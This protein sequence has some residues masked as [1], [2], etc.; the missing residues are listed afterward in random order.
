[1]NRGQV[2]LKSICSMCLLLPLLAGCKPYSSAGLFI[3]NRSGRDIIVKANLNSDEYVEYYVCSADNVELSSTGR[4][5][6]HI[7]EAFISDFVSNPDASVQI[8]VEKGDELIL[9]KEWK[10]S[11]KDE[12]GRQFF[13]ELFLYRITNVE[14]DGGSHYLYYFIINQNDIES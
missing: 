4:Y 10:Y 11:E 14:P 2:L 6:Y 8:Y 5:D 9:V 1:M 12:P 3:D 7:K 13:N